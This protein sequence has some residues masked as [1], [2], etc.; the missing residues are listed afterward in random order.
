MTK[1][2]KSRQ[3]QARLTRTRTIQV[4]DVYLGDIIVIKSGVQAGRYHVLDI[5]GT[6][7]LK[8]RRFWCRREGSGRKKFLLYRSNSRGPINVAD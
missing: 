2:P 6:L 7:D 4:R 5:G 3:N 8:G 1:A